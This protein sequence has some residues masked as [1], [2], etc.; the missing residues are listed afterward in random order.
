MTVVPLRYA[1][2]LPQMIH[3]FKYRRGLT[4]GR[5]LATLLAR[6]VSGRYV[7][8][9]LPEA[10]VPVPLAWTRLLWRGYNQAELLAVWVGRTLSVPVAHAR[11]RRRRGPPPQTALDAKARRGNL[12]DAFELADAAPLPRS[13]AIVDDVMTTGATLRELA[14][15]LLDGGCTQIHCWALARTDAFPV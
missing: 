13:V 3:R 2:P 6:T 11:V 9:P 4:S 7:E 15:V 12:R 10:I 1:P 5:V 8:R 14:R